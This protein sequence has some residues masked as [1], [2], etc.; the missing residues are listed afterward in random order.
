MT[1]SA[2]DR[3][4]TPRHRRVEQHGIVSAKVRP[5]RHASV[6]D[7]SAGGALVETTHRL[8]PG[9]AVELQLETSVERA[10]VRG[11][12]LR[13]TVAGLHP[14]SVCYRGAIGFDRHLPWFVPDADGYGVHGHESRSA[15]PRRADATPGIF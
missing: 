3:R 14:T 9:T 6:V 12:V 1:D 13:C 2:D 5:G 7:V 11:R 15:T 4:R 10:T 8:L